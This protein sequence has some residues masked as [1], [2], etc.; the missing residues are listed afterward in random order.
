MRPEHQTI[1]VDLV[2]GGPLIA[3]N[4]TDAI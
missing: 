2:V 4:F 1:S 3:S